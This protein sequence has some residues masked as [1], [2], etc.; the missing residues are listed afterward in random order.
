MRHVRLRSL[1]GVKRT[2]LVAAHMAASDPKRTYLVAPHDA[3]P[4][5][6]QLFYT[7][8]IPFEP[9]TSGQPG[10]GVAKISM[11]VRPEGKNKQ[12]LWNA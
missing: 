10:A 4:I 6:R 9:I 5:V 1:L 12:G 8:V 11:P 7:V 3:R 2:S